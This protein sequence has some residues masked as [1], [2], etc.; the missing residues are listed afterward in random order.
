L[1]KA[2]Q[3]GRGEE[4]DKQSTFAN[5]ERGGNQLYEIIPPQP[6]LPPGPKL[7]GN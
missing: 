4:G 1:S 2:T 7:T 6:D 3:L 5:I